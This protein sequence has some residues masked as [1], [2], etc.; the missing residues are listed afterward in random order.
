MY[1]GKGKGCESSTECN[2][3]NVMLFE[4]KQ[5]YQNV[6][7]QWDAENKSWFPVQLSHCFD[8]EVV[9]KQEC[10]VI[11]VSKA[12][13]AIIADLKTRERIKNGMVMTSV[14]TA[15]SY[16][17]LQKKY[18]EFTEKEYGKSFSTYYFSD[19]DSVFIDKFITLLK[20]RGIEQGHGGAVPTALRKRYGV[21]IKAKEELKIADIDMEI[22]KSSKV[23][24]KAAH[25]NAP[26]KTLPPVVL[27]KIENID[28]SL[29]SKLENFYIDLFLFSYY[30]GGKANVDVAYLTWDC[31]KDDMLPYE[32]IKFTKETEI[33]FLNKTKDIVEKY[34]PQC[35][36][37]YV[38]PVFIYKH[39]YKQIDPKKIR[40]TLNQLV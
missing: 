24:M 27:A 38:L 8:K 36:G 31:I 21:F 37:N 1:K 4:L 5:K 33:P 16:S 14:G 26:P 10:K 7:E 28:R 25:N 35:F 20:K 23:E 12:I 39:Y 18:V 19:I 15:K 32:R 34:K 11:T 30:T 29:F 6:A 2:E 22:L 17:V 3:K 40:N 13:D 9:K